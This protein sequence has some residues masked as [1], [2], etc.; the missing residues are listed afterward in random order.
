MNRRRLLALAVLGGLAGCGAASRESRSPA[1]GRQ[2]EGG[3]S[4]KT[5][6]PYRGGGE[7]LRRAHGVVLRNVGPDERYVTVAVDDGDSPVFV[8]SLALDRGESAEYPSLVGTAGEY[9]VVV[10]SVRSGRHE[11][12]REEYAW[13]VG[14]ALSDLE[15]AVG[16]GV[17]FVPVVRCQPDCP[18]VSR[19]GRAVGFPTEA[20]TASVR[21]QPTLRVE[22][23]DSVP[24]SVRLRVD[25]PEHRLRY[26]YDLPAGARLVLPV[27]ERRGAAT[28]AAESGGDRARGRWCEVDTELF[29]TVRR[30]RIDVGCGGDHA[31]GVLVN[32]DDR[33]HALAVRFETGGATAVR[34]YRLGPGESRR[35]PTL[36]RRSG[37][38]TL[39]LGTAAG[40]ETVYRWM[41]C[42]PVGPVWIVIAP[43]GR[44][45]ADLA[46]P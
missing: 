18:P 3:Q 21:Y 15:I 5:A 26:R 19:G 31:V 29:V 9:R 33:P 4:P 36:F 27:G 39:S 23:R 2:T 6:G 13:R 32:D 10:E 11:G 37:P 14:G 1:G 42:P 45:T 38:Y 43:G 44:V 7:P 28:V 30:G 46:V 34:R 25:G 8:D 41:T 16:A 22:N 24:R 12:P 20:E 35:D 17:R 40:P